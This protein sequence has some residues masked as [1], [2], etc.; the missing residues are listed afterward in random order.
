MTNFPFQNF[1]SQRITKIGT[2][3]GWVKA[4]TGYS[5]KHT[6]KKIEKLIENLKQNK[7]PYQGLLNP[8]FQYYDKVFLKVLEQE[9]DKGEWIF[10]N[11]YQKNSIQEVFQ[12]LDEETNFQQDL[13]IMGS[14]F[15]SAFVKAFFKT[16]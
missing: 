15:S 5:F 4:S 12:Y 3:G 9:N 11:F 14:L 6:E 10:E 7:L 1:H 16:L 2:A 8:K 13:K